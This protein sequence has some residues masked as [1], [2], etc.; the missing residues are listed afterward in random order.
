MTSD[1]YVAEMCKYK[2]NS[3]REFAQYIF[4]PPL[5]AARPDIKQALRAYLPTN[6]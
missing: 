1:K 6:A 2:P 4:A 5:G 3:P